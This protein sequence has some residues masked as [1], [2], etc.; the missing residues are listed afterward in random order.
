MKSGTRRGS[1]FCARRLGE[2]ER[3]G[4]GEGRRGVP[5]LQT[6][7]RNKSGGCIRLERWNG[8]RKRH[9]PRSVPV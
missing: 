6:L 5:S 2:G 3:D 7:L 9:K 1:C 8:R 4:N